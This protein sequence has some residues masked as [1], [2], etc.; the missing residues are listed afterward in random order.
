[1]LGVKKFPA[2]PKLCMVV[3]ILYVPKSN[4]D[5]TLHALSI[6]EKPMQVHVQKLYNNT[7]GGNLPECQRKV[8]PARGTA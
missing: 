3:G 1:M 7:T 6:L 4:N 2:E 5:K 8:R